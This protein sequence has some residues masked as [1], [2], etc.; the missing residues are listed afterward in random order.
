M[1]GSHFP[2]NESLLL[3]HQILIGHQ[4]E[5]PSNFLLANVSLLLI[6]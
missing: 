3:I 6:L 1:S 2:V 4:K 5:I